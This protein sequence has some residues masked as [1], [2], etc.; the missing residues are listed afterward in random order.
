MCCPDQLV[1]SLARIASVADAAS[2][3]LLSGARKT[4]GRIFGE[5]QPRLSFE[6][7]DVFAT[8]FEVDPPDAA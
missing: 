8:R 3:Q 4:Y 2:S 1:L 5:G 6:R 7:S